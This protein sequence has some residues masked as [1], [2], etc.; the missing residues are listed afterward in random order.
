M[1]DQSQ[2]VSEMVHNILSNADIKAICK[3]RAF[4]DTAA[5]SK[6]LFE[7]TFLSSTGLKTA[8]NTLTPTEI[9]VLHLLRFENRTVEVSFFE[10]VYGNPKTVQRYY[11]G[12]FTQQFKPIFDSVQNR[13]VRKG[14]L[15][16]TEAKSNALNKTKMELWRYYFPPEFGAYLPA[17]TAGAFHSDTA[18][19]T[20]ADPFRA[21]LL[22]IVRELESRS[23]FPGPIKLTGGAIM[24]NKQE[25]SEKALQEW[26]KSTWEKEI[27][28]SKPKYSPGQPLPETFMFLGY[29]LS[30]TEQRTYSP[31][32][33]ILYIFSQLK[34]GEWLTLE[35]LDIPLDI[36]Y[37][38]TLHPAAQA[39]CLAGYESG[40]L[41]RL[42]V[43]ERVYYKLADRLS[44]VTTISPQ[45]YL[46]MLP[47]GTVQINVGNI[48]YRALE[49]LNRGTYLEADRGQLKASPSVTKLLDATE[50]VRKHEIMDYLRKHSPAFQAIFQKFDLEW[51]KLILHQNLL[52]A[53]VTS[54]DLRVKLQKAFGTASEKVVFL[55]GE[56][57]AFA[58]D[59][60]G[61]IEKVVKKAGHVVK[62]IQAK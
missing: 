23:N 48:P 4:P 14:L 54:L 42:Q 5:S 57:M 44:E 43:S 27:E 39:I 9:A 7:H 45:A 20:R 30:E 60:I 12:T 52:L 8:I 37:S 28:R 18:G 16:I 19:S 1:P 3:S 51:G 15:I 59:I 55:P 26:R 11:Y 24:V 56:F 40:F 33:F 17:L 32:P 29:L 2:L 46:K 36:F 35:Q 53:R 6:T 25:F 58:P 38:T 49:I 22:G 62:T 10:R 41:A 21:E 13:L 31:L 61:E 34:P 50:A 47:D